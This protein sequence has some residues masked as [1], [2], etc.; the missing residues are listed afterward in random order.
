MCYENQNL[1]L[2]LVIV[3]GNGPT[4]FGRSWWRVI[5]LNWSKI[6]HLQAPGLQEVL[7]KYSAV[8]KENLGA[9]TGP[10]ATIEVDPE[11]TPRFCKARPLM[12]VM[13]EKV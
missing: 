1:T 11:A 13:R 5:K 9:F 2:P 4:L 12:Y 7:G 8:F 10:A 6:Y 3:R